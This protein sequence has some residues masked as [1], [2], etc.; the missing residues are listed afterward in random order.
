MEKDN[1]ILKCQVCNKE[2]N[3]LRYMTCF[4]C[5]TLEEIISMTFEEIKQ[6]M[7]LSETILLDCYES[8]AMLK[9]KL[10]IHRGCTFTFNPKKT[11]HKRKIKD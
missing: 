10:L 9:L 5:A 1:E 6:Q 8:L 4:D 2:T 3:D 7:S 11:Y